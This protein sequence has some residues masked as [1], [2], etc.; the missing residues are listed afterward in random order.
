M[1]RSAANWIELALIAIALMFALAVMAALLA[2]P[3]RSQSPDH[4]SADHWYDA[5][6]CSRRDCEALPPE[7]VEDVPGGWHV[8]YLSKR[9][10]A[11]N[12]FV[13]S[14]K[15]RDSQDGRFHGCATPDRFLCLYV[16]RV[17]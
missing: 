1:K 10:F 16:P 11:V 13:P 12:A 3:G 6:C 7:A 9:G 8:R 2:A 4:F 14:A 17:A 5:V 15:A